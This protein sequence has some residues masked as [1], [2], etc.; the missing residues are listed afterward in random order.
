MR[1]FNHF[2]HGKRIAHCL[3]IEND[4]V[5]PYWIYPP[6][7]APPEGKVVA[8]HMLDVID[9]Y[10]VS[11]ELKEVSAPYWDSAGNDPDLVMDIGL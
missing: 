11:G 7:G 1:Y 9:R 8:S 2:E 6:E 5:E 10:V 3:V 4:G